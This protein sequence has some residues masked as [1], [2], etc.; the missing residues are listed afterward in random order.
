MNHDALSWTD[1]EL[2]LRPRSPACISYRRLV[3]RWTLTLLTCALIIPAG[4]CSKAKPALAERDIDPQRLPITGSVKYQGRPASGLMVTF[5]PLS[6]ETGG[7]GGQVMDGEF[8]IQAIDGLRPGKYL[9]RIYDV[10]SYSGEPARDG[11]GNPVPSIKVPPQYNDSSKL[12]I[13]VKGGD[14]NHFSFEIN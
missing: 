7:S 10:A 14:A 2:D 6:P 12:T 13:E 9:V 4:S 11:N 3:L 5:Q 8:S 1:T